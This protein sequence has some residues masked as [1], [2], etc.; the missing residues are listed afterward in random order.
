LVV[1]LSERPL[2]WHG[3]HASI[4]QTAT[5]TEEKAE[6][7]KIGLSRIRVGRD[8]IPSL[9]LRRAGSIGGAIEA[10][11]KAAGRAVL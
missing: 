4:F 9:K 1:A 7:L 3:H 11:A 8:R 5:V 2:D 6:R 10:L